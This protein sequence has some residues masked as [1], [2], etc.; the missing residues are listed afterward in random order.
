MRI[1]RLD[2]FE[3]ENTNF[4]EMSSPLGAILT[5][6]S[7]QELLRKISVVDHDLH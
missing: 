1:R 6:P 3:L 5:P 7:L 2:T 4:F